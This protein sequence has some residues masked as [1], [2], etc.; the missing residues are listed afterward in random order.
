MARGALVFGAASSDNVLCGTGAAID[1]L[2]TGSVIAVVNPSTLASNA[3]IMGK[4]TGTAGWELQLSAATG[5]LIFT[6]RRG[7][8]GANNI[9]FISSSLTLTTNAWAIVAASWDT[10]GNACHI[11]IGSIA[12]ALAEPTYSTSQIGAGAIADDSAVPLYIGNAPTL[13]VAWTGRIGMAGVFGAALSLADFQSWAKC[14]R[15]TVGA[16]VAKAFYRLGKDGADAIEYTGL[17]N[18]TVTGATQ[19]DGPPIVGGWAQNDS[20]LYLMA[21]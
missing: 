16:T 12:T 21:A 14:P 8:G 1:N 3:R 19:G 20:G 9:S 13:T 17:G 4:R 15:K 7:A 11:Y 6:L 10:V 5:N 2:A 18:G